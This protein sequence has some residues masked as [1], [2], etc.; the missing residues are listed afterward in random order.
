MGRRDEARARADDGIVCGPRR[1]FTFSASSTPAWRVILRSPRL[2][3]DHSEGRYRCFED[4]LTIGSRSRFEFAVASC[5]RN[6]R[7]RHSPP[8]TQGRLGGSRPRCRTGQVLRDNRRRRGKTCYRSVIRRSRRG[9]EHGATPFES[10]D[11]DDGG[12]GRGGTRRAGRRAGACR[13]RGVRSAF[14]RAEEVDVRRERADPRRRVRPIARRHEHGRAV[15]PD[16]HRPRLRRADGLHDAAA[17]RRRQRRAQ[18][19]RRI[20][21]AARQVRRERRRDRDVGLRRR[22]AA[23]RPLRR[24][25]R[26]LL[27]PAAGQAAPASRPIRAR[28]ATC[29]SARSTPSPRRRARSAR[30]TC[31]PRTTSTR[32]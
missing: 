3:Q 11:V 20:V 16:Q 8:K 7:T 28:R 5:S 19:V 25:G 31:C 21:G 2:P 30:P 18:G 23:R 27:F 4:A 26:P 1:D 24:R 13:R 32:S 17:V 22:L 14:A 15:E 6:S 10:D 12:D 29:S 9:S